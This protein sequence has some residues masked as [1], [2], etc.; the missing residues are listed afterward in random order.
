MVAFCQSQTQELSFDAE[1]SLPFI[2]ST[3]L[4]EPLKLLDSLQK[5]PPK[6]CMRQWQQWHLMAC[7]PVSTESMRMSSA[8]PLH[9]SIPP[10][11]K[12][13]LMECL[14][15]N[16]ALDMPLEVTERASEVAFTPQ[17]N[18]FMP[19][20]MKMTESVSALRACIGLFATTIVQKRYN[21][22]HHMKIEIDLQAA[23]LMLSSLVLF[24]INGKGI[25]DQEVSARGAHLDK[26][27][28]SETYRAMATNM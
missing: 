16:K 6:S 19:T 8:E 27:H 28:I 15:D 13:I 5:W 12:R 17:I 23:T 3:L 11:A 21:A 4:L 18:S 1:E 26:G 14:L 7:Q 20:P 2:S 9:S 10:E 24:E 25:A 22:S